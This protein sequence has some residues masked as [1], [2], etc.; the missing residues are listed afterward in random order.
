MMR[1]PGML[2]RGILVVQA[3]GCL[4]AATFA[5]DFEEDVKGAVVT[6]TQKAGEIG[7]LETER[8]RYE[9]ALNRYGDE[10]DRLLNSMVGLISHYDTSGI[11]GAWK[12]LSGKGKD[13]V[14]KIEGAGP[15]KLKDIGLEDFVNG[16]KKIYELNQKAMIAWSVDVMV[17]LEAADVELM[18]RFQE[19]LGK[20]RDGDKVIEAQLQAC[21]T[22]A[23]KNLKEYS[24]AMAETVV[25][26]QVRNWLSSKPW[27]QLIQWVLDQGQKLFEE[28][29]KDVK[30]KRRLKEILKADVDFA[31][32]ARNQL[33][34]E[35][36]EEVYK[37]GEEAA[38]ELAGAG[39]Q[40][41]YHAKDWEEF[42]DRAL[43]DLGLVRER[44]KDNSKK[45]FDDL[46]PAFREEL[47]EKFSFVLDDGDQLASWYEEIDDQ[48]KTVDDL[49]QKAVELTQELSEG[50]FKK[51]VTE[52]LDDAKGKFIAYKK[53]FLEKKQEAD[54]EM[55]KE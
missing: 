8:R 7:M 5:G 43:K 53:V 23:S 1:R 32:N 50:S 29:Y 31:V 9:E 22:E 27:G 16:E 54:E 52:S 13:L 4:T 41:D 34:V 51:A 19:D 45:L 15:Y 17:K 14:D 26:S 25:Q 28:R 2:M 11:Q 10:R 38:K 46:L 33:S 42:A 21:Q 40:N 47:K 24:K 30:E 3:V 37:K 20:V 18:K 44:A 55:K 35:W 12:D 36:I 49:F 39:R 6:L 48:F